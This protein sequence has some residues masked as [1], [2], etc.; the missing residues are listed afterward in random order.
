MHSTLRRH[1]LQTP[2]V[3]IPLQPQIQRK[4][5]WVWGSRQDIP[6]LYEISSYIEEALSGSSTDFFLLGHDGH[7]TNSWFL[8]CY[9]QH[10]PLSV[11][12]QTPW[13]GAFTESAA[14]ED[15]VKRRFQVLERLITSVDRALVAGISFPGRLIVQQS[16]VTSPR[17]GWL[18]GDSTCEW[19]E[20]FA[21][22]MT[23]ALE[24]LQTHAQNV[25]P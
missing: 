6:R 20:E 9:L 24:S 3:P 12:V 8:H 23:P 16:S 15:A 7:G 5:D 14:A 2:L 13:G 17:W 1:R 4:R 22:A 21:N 11:F 25:I 18:T 10:G 19:Q